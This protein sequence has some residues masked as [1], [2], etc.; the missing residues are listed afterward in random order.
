[1]D[2]DDAMVSVVGSDIFEIETLRHHVVELNRG[3]LPFP[4]NRIGDVDV[5]FW[6]IERS[7][8]FVQLVRDTGPIECL[9]QLSLSFIPRLDFA[10]EFRRTRPELQ[11]ERQAEIRIRPAQESQQPFD[12]LADLVRHYET[13]CVVL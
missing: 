8:T 9:F 1:M 4:P 2:H 3:A 11:F 5:D 7:I 10:E 13:M 12:L 6:P